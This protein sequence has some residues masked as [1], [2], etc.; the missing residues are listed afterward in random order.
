ME[1]REGKELEEDTLPARKE[2]CVCERERVCACVCVWVIVSEKAG[3]QLCVQTWLRN[4]YTSGVHNYCL[5][6]VPGKN[7]PPL[8]LSLS[9]SLFPL[10][11]TKL[12]AVLSN[13]VLLVLCFSFNCWWESE[14]M[15]LLRRARLRL[16]DWSFSEKNIFL[17][18]PRFR[19]RM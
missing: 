7:F 9:Q 5:H 4:T 8:P 14:K 10:F 11:T 3:R 2:E 1:E 15:W 18:S 6:S 12:V 17:H 16:K 13:W 19:I